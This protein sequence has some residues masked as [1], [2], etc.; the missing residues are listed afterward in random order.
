MMD[1]YEGMDITSVRNFE[2][3]IT[4]G[5][6][7]PHATR[8]YGAPPSISTEEMKKIAQLKGN[9]IKGS[10]YCYQAKKLEKIALIQLELVEK[11]YGN[12]ITIWPADEY[13]LP[14]LIIS[15]DESPGATHFFVDCMPLADCVTDSTY[16]ENYLDP[17]EPVWKKCKFIRDL[18][19]FPDYEVNLYSWM[20]ATASPYIITRRVPPNKPKGIREDLIKL[21]VDYIKVYID[22]WKS[23]E[24]Q[25]P[26]YMNTL[27]QRKAT[28][29]NLFRTRKDP[30]GK[31]WWKGERYLG[32]E[33]THPMITISY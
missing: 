2:K 16:L 29:R 21:G 23:A 17:L 13:A 7:D 18:P 22:M 9:V 19:N 33:L 30:D 12:I 20:R 10:M 1:E 5:F 6:V 26:G 4:K 15:M 31:F 3:P 28:L 24:V 11:Y 25:E 8:S 32:P 27:N 14:I